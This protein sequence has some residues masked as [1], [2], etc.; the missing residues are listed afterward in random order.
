MT[1]KRGHPGAL[2]RNKGVIAIVFN[3]GRHVDLCEVGIT[4]CPHFLHSKPCEYACYEGPSER[5]RMAG[6]GKD[7][8]QMSQKRR[9]SGPLTVMGL[10]VRVW[11]F[12]HL[13][14][15][16]SGP[17]LVV[18]RRFGAFPWLTPLL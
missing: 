5:S 11:P 14:L 6:A 8:S 18:S 17:L 2:G 3:H 1:K 16:L 10:S 15:A 9:V 4:P 12:R 7:E 13:S